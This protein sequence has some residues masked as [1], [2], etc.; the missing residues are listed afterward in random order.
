MRVDP[1]SRKI[2]IL[3][4]VVDRYKDGSVSP[5]SSE[6]KEYLARKG[7]DMNDAALRTALVRYA[8]Q[9]LLHREWGA[10]GRGYVYSPNN[11]TSAVIEYFKHGENEQ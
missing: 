2:K 3:Q 5:L 1:N 10:R 7:I 8:R 6:I 11:R 9:G 4:A